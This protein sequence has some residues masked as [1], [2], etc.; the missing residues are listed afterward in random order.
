MDNSEM[1]NG[2]MRGSNFQTTAVAIRLAVAVS[3]LGGGQ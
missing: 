1:Y 3:D 2:E